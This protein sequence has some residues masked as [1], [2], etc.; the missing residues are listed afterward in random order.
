[1]YTSLL[2]AAPLRYGTLKTARMLPSVVGLCLVAL[3][4]SALTATQAAPGNRYVDARIC[5]GCHSQIAGNHLQTGMGR[6]LFRPTPAN[7]VEDYIGNNGFY[8]ALSETHYSMILRDGAYYQRR[9]QI[10]FGGKETRVEESRIDYVLGSGNHARSYLHRTARGTLIELPLGWYA[11]KGGHWGMSPGFDSRHPATRRLASYECVFCHDGYPHIPAGHDA[12]GSEPVFSGDLPEGIDCQRCH[13]PG[14]S[15]VDTA[16]TAG[17][18]R[19]MIRASIVNPARLSAKLRMDLCMQCHLE[20]TSTAIPSL[21]RRFNRGPFSFTAGEPLSAFLLAFDHAPGAQHDDKFEIVGSSAYRLRR[22]RCFRESKDALTCDT[23]H[24]PH[25][26]PRGEEAVRHYSQACRQCHAAAIDGLVTKGTHPVSTDC[27]TCHMPK[28]RTEDV[29]HVVMTDHLIQRRPALR[30]L[31]AELAER[32]PTEAD[33]YHGEVVPYYPSTLSPAGADALYRALAQVSMKNNLRAGVAELARQMAL[34]QPREAEWYIQLGD[35]WLASGEPLKA[36]AAY[37]RAVRLRPQ[38]VRGLQSLAK[39]LQASGQAVRS[40]EV[41]QQAIQI[42]PSDAGSWYQFSALASK[43]GRSSEA[44]EKMENVIALDPDL[45]GE[46]TTLAGIQAATGQTE[47]AEAALR[48]ALRIDPYDAAAWDLA[49]R[50]RAEKGEFP[51]ALYDFEKAIRHR[52]KFAPYL[53]DYALTLTSASEFGRAQESAEAAA[54]ADPNLAEPHAL[55]GGLL[56]RKRQLPE[57]AREYQEAIRLRPDFGRA[58]LGLASA[59]VSQGE[60]RQAVEQL[61]EATKDRDPEVARLAAG[62]LQRLG[63]R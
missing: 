26:I 22:S 58:R 62:A 3:M 2:P 52:P 8:H 1:M 54:R 51:E 5:A 45:P 39:G 40:A 37:E 9:W 31:L 34:Q 30:D 21:I 4:G 59:L 25:R 17:S 33:E 27:V 53:Y 63:E 28:R 38:T 15:H 47:R 18:T 57:A 61:R 43:L 48:E 11:E 50:V 7:T 19:E 49:G 24:D 6:S 46:Y 12:P 10:G 29:V 16:Q 32:H 23:C 14:G 35:G 36:V 60:T 56:A 44:I 20:P 42:A 13:G 55:L 41:L